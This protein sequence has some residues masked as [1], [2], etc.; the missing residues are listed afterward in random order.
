MA[1]DIPDPS[2]LGFKA[3]KWQ[4][5]LAEHKRL[6]RQRGDALAEQA[7]LRRQLVE[8]EQADTWAH[9]AAIREGKPDPGTPATDAVKSAQ[10]AVQRSVDALT[11]AVGQ[12]EK[13]LRSAVASERDA[14]LA[15][16]ESAVDARRATLRAAVDAWDESRTELAEAV[17]LREYL[18]DWPDGR[19]KTGHGYMRGGRKGTQPMPA[20]A[21][22]A[23]LREDAEPPPAKAAPPA[24]AGKL[25]PRVSEFGVTGPM[26]VEPTSRR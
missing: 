14:V 10:A 15:A 24:Y 13:E 16:V 11:V 9:A 6:Q 22:L 5:A 12:T 19:F 26:N 20:D 21:V 17:A 8:A 2:V 23:M 1:R 7:E 25:L 18:A 4:A 3:P